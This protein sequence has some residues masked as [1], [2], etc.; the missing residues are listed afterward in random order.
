MFSGIH[1]AA[2]YHSDKGIG[3]YEKDTHREHKYLYGVHDPA[4][5]GL[6]FNAISDWFLGN[7]DKGLRRVG[8]AVSL[9]EELDHPVSY[10][11]AL[12]F[13]AV[14]S[15]FRRDAETAAL[16]AELG[17]DVCDRHGIAAWRPAMRTIQGWTLTD[18]GGGSAIADMEKGMQA[19]QA[20]G[21]KLFWPFFLALQGETE[22]R[23]G[24]PIRGLEKIEA[25]LA[26]AE[27]TGEHWIDA[28]LHRLR[29]EMLLAR[30]ARNKTKAAEAF[31]TARKIAHDQGAVSMEL[32]AALS[33]TN[34]WG[35]SKR[36][37]EAHTL[38]S[39]VHGRFT[40]HQ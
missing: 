17:V 10:A 36:R 24:N 20:T 16:Y 8:E 13:S 25:G 28:E 39:S 2:N 38:L 12:L 14:Y 30:S 19:W 18:L 26:H 35:D 15:V 22:G 6:T 21:N 31:A 9:G 40:H 32:R 3:I 27:S 5:C 34:L 4:A 1:E 11:V 29:G 7:V 37:E 33:L 23:A